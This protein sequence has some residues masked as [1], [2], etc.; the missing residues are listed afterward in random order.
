VIEDLG[1]VTSSLRLECDV[2]V[3][4][5][6]PGGIVLALECASRGL[7]VV[8]LESGGDAFEPDLQDLSE[9][10]SL[11]AAM[12]APLSL[13]IRRQ[14]GGT[15]VIWGG[16]CVPYDPV[17]FDVRDAACGASWP[18]TYNEIAGYFQA[19]C[20]WFA[21]GRAVFDAGEIPGLPP[22][23]IPGFHDGE[24]RASSL[25]RWS[26]PTNFGTLYRTRLL[27]DPRIRVYSHVTCQRVICDDESSRASRLECVTAAG[28]RIEVGARSFVVAA[29]G[30]ESTRLLMTSRGPGGGPPGG[31]SDK[32]GRFYMAHTEGVIAA[33]RL[34]TPSKSTIYG[35]EQD[36]DGVYV[37]RRFTFSR[38]FLRREG[39][40]NIA[41]WLTNP[42][43]PDARHDSGPLSFVYLT[44]KSPAGRFLAPDA[45]RLSLTGERVPGAPYGGVES[46][47]ALSHLGNMGRHP[48]DTLRFIGDFGP[49]RFLARGRRA[50]GFFVRQ[51][52]NVYPLQYHGE[53]LPH[54]ESRVALSE[55]LDATGRPR[56]DIDLR[57][58]DADVEGV[59]RAHEAWDRALRDQGVG[60]LEYL[61]ADR[62]DAVRNRLG[63]GFHQ[64]GTTR[65]SAHPRD[66]VVGPNLAVH[67][68]DN[69]HV[70]SSSVF[71]TSGQANS[72][73]MIVA[74]A[75]RLA[76]HLVDDLHRQHS[77]AATGSR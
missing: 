40:P 57:F 49:R 41:G 22:S 16:R 39:L 4:G 10:A 12:H 33:V 25:E 44:L 35:Y 74:F 77:L 34:C 48:V 3:V 76:E 17:D 54:P 18:I 8:L 32:L 56:L 26:L 63:G 64:V 11:D 27:T 50:P 61:Q 23:I 42:E 71:V 73:F 5:A 75:V 37:R 38:E 66:G 7:N 20:D 13:A 58:S 59:V 30:L 24:V 15:S 43:L 65:M 46:T 31:Q 6:G 52:G 62:H 45:Q 67:G 70:V 29:G 36:I 60:C 51:P 2:A 53:H 55:Q 1:A 14:I 69:L 72:T 9:A 19:S 68:V 47:G 28:A 21:C